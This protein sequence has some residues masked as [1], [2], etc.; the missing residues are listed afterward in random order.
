MSTDAKRIQ[1]LE[2]VSTLHQHVEILYVVDGYEITLVYDESPI[3]G[4]FH[5]LTLADAIDRA[6]EK[7]SA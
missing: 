7:W 4:P 3:H 5:G 1:W 6:M 2:T